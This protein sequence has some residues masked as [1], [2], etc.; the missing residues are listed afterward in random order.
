M[1]SNVQLVNLPNSSS[2]GNFVDATFTKIDSYSGVKRRGPLRERPGI[3]PI[4]PFLRYVETYPQI[5][6]LSMSR[7][8]SDFLR[9]IISTQTEVNGLVTFKRAKFLCLFHATLQFDKLLL[10]TYLNRSF[11]PLFSFIINRRSCESNNIT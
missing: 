1:S 9:G 7:H 5:V 2:E 3:G 11:L 6:F 10:G 8:S 4:S